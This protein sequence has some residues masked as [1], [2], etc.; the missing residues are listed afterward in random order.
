MLLGCIADDFTGASDLANALTRRGMATML[1]VGPVNGVSPQV[2]EAGVV[3]LKTRSIA[4]GDAVAQSLAALEWLKAQ[5]CRQ[6]LF[7]YCSTFN[8]TPEGNIGPVAEALLDRLGAEAA[9]VCPAFPAAGRTVYQGHLFVGDRLLNQSGMENHPLNPMTDP[10]IRRWLAL[11]AKTPVGAIRHAVV[12]KGEAAIRAAFAA[13]A[14]A[15]AKLIVADAVSEDDLLAIG[16]A[17]R[18]HLLV[19]GGS[20][21]AIG[22]PDNFRKMGHLRGTATATPAFKGPGAALCG[23]CSSASNR[24]VVVYSRGR[25]SFAIHAEDVIVGRATAA[26]LAAAMMEKI[27]DAPIAYS[28]ADPARVAATQEKFGKDRVAQAMEALFGNLAKSLV[29][30]G[31]RRLVVGGGETSGAVVNAL[32]LKAMA[33]GPEIDPGVPALSCMS[34]RPLGLALKSGNFGADDFFEKALARLAIG[35]GG[36]PS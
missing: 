13:E 21:I 32:G 35:E 18:D 6:F 33:I 14:G 30:A 24:Q 27:A 1:F 2:C 11:Q 9:L 26:S 16:L 36:H 19:T 3:A 31:V 10:D 29:D 5:G 12:A 7:K 22:L 15:G 34:P 8:S 25:P 17:A 4:V 23:S 20:G 28:T